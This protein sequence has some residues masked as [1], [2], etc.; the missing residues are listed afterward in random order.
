MLIA[1]GRAAQAYKVYRE[2]IPVT[3]LVRELVGDAGYA[4]GGVRPFGISLLLAGVDHG[5]QAQIDP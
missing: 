3:Q 1:K 5:P 2:T 4:A